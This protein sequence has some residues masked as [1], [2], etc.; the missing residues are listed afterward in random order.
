[1][2]Q[3]RN[4]QVLELLANGINPINNEEFPADHPCQ[5]PEVI[6][7][8]FNAITMIAKGHH[9]HS[10]KKVILSPGEPAKKG[11]PWTKEEDRSLIDAFKENVS[12][13]QLA[14]QHERSQI[15]IEKRLMKLGLL[16]TRYVPVLS[17]PADPV[18]IEIPV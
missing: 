17:P 18:D 10:Q 5:N 6:R 13:E 12:L 14:K 16:P 3:D 15:A 9:F 4:L 7:A 8:L 2:H 1:M 11:V